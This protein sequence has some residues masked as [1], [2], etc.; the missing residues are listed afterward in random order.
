MNFLYVKRFYYKFALPTDSD[1]EVCS[2]G[3]SRK[4]RRDPVP[5]QK[6]E[7]FTH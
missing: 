7:F 4:L 3:H 2:C 5:K 1:I 6:A